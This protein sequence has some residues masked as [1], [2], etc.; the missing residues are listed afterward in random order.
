MKK[1]D[2]VL[3]LV[4]AGLHGAALFTGG[5]AARNAHILSPQGEQLLSLQQ[6]RQLRVAGALGDTVLEVR[7]GKVRFLESPCRRKYCIHGG[8]IGRA[9]ARLVCLPNKVAVL[10]GAAA[11]GFDSLNY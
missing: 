10:A 9:G 7:D 3:I 4:L 1:G 6:P 5:G 8:W 11:S 2:L